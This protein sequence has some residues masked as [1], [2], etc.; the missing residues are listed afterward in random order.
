MGDYLLV[1]LVTDEEMQQAK[2]IPVMPWEERA[3]VVRAC[4]WVDEV[5]PGKYYVN[6]DI[7]D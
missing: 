1:A 5:I 3:M 4:K 2:G 7:L 6:C